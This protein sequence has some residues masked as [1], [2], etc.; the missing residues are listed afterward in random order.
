MVC[1]LEVSHRINDVGKASFPLEAAEE[2][3]FPVFFTF[4]RLPTFLHLWPPFSTAKPVML[5][6]SDHSS[7]VIFTFD[8]LRTTEMFFA[9][10]DICD[11]IEPTHII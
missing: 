8:H 4:Y 3:T 2:Y 9:F 1:G 5:Y 11:Y 6:L 10:K 7:V